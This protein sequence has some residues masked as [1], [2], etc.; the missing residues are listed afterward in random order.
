MRVQTLS[1]RARPTQELLRLSRMRRQDMAIL[2]DS[3][4][5]SSISESV[6]PV[7]MPTTRSSAVLR[8]RVRIGGRL[9]V[10]E[11]ALLRATSEELRC[12]ETKSNNNMSARPRTNHHE[13]P[14]HVYFFLFLFSCSFPSPL[15]SSPFCS[16]PPSRNSDA[17][18]HSR[19]FS[20]YPLRFVP[21]IFYREN[22]LG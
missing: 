19:L 4:V 8:C 5:G 16:L 7:S 21:C 12:G 1:E 2:F 3:G 10:F 14:G 17:G 20:P 9:E 6:R 13:W 15:L 22:N 11:F 18:S